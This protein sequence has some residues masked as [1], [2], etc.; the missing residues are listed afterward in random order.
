MAITYSPGGSAEQRLSLA[1]HSK[2][3][4]FPDTFARTDTEPF[5]TELLLTRTE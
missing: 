2:S 4:S 1:K 5:T 3:A